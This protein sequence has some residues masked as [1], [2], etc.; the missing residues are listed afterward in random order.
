MYWKKN[1]VLWTWTCS[2]V[3]IFLIPLSA[4]FINYNINISAMKKEVISVNKLTFDNASDNIDHYLGLL[5]ENYVYAFLNDNFEELK[6]R[7]TID[8]VFYRQTYLLQEQL[9]YYRNGVDDMFCMIYMRNKDYLITSENSCAAELYYQGM[10]H[11]YSDFIDYED[12]KE[13][14]NREYSED[15]TVGKGINYWT[16]ED[17]LIYAKT[18]NGKRKESYNIIVSVPLAVIEKVTEYLNEDSWMIIHIEGQEPLIFHKGKFTEAPEWIEEKD[19]FIRMQK[20]SIV[21]R[22]SYELVFSEQSIMD[23]LQGV[24]TTFWVNFALT[25]MM[26]IMGI[27]ILLWINYR[28]IHTMISEFGEEESDNINEFEHMKRKLYSLMQEKRTSGQLLEMQQKELMNSR[29]LM[30]M[31]GRGDKRKGFEVEIDGGFV[32]NNKIGLVGFMVSVGENEADYDELQFFVVDN[33]FSELVKEERFYHL[34]DGCFIFYLFDLKSGDEEFWR[35]EII[36]KAEYLCSMLYDKWGISIF[37]AVGEIGEEIGVVKHL[38]QNIMDA[39][40]YQKMAGGYGVLDVRMLPDHSELHMLEEYLGQKFSYAFAQ[41]DINSAKSIV[42]QMFSTHDAVTINTTIMKMRTYEM[43]SIVMGIFR[44]YVTDMESQESAF[45]YL[46]TL[47]RAQTKADMKNCF[48][49]LLQFQIDV[50]SRQQVKE[51]KGIVSKVVNYVQENYM[52][53]NLNLNSIAEGL[54]KNPRYISRTFKEETKNGII[55]YI[56]SVRIEKAKELMV[57]R[58]FTMQEVAE[59]VG[60]TNVRTFRRAFEKITGNMPGNWK[61]K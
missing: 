53:C 17:C 16:Q 3:L 37:G 44:E 58:K 55:D 43:F 1:S 9:R 56:N 50:I 2:Y 54:G 13:I 47:S 39:L 42:E 29:L 38:Y 25:M 11:Q 7:G 27:I 31:K 61:R 5:R 24:R 52:D 4:T 45:K 6:S 48:C 30:L 34:E 51:G 19:F 32:L 40:E 57:S 33:I 36:K 35:Q 14:L 49:D 8:A 18:V 41:K 21:P 46:E 15:Y 26:E 22:I 60:Y 20:E 12:W 59:Q 23:E 28:P 10:K